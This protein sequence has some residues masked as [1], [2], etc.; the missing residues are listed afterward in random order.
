MADK[1][2]ILIVDDEV[3]SCH[4]IQRGL[5]RQGFNVDVAF[6]GKQALDKIENSKYDFIF[7]DFY[8]PDL[9]GAEVL[10]IIKDKN[11]ESIIIMTSGYPKDDDLTKGI[12]VNEFLEKP[13]SF[14]QIKTIIDKYNKKDK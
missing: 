7:L 4:F 8:M 14:G 6:D 12:K 13:F 5:T 9:T 2:N 10:K 3:D 1:N 11:I